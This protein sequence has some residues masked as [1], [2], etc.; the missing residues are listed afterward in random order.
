VAPL[1][2]SNRVANMQQ[3][4]GTGSKGKFDTPRELWLCWVHDLKSLPVDAYKAGC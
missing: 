4:E 3:M 2:L 1:D